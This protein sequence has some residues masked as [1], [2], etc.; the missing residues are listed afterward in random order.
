VT[1]SQEWEDVYA[2]E[3]HLSVWPWTDLVSLCLRHCQPKAEMKVLE[4]GCGSGANIPFFKS[5][6]ADYFAID[7]SPTAVA[8]LRARYPQYADQIIVGDFTVD[9]PFTNTFDLVIDRAAL[10]HNTTEAIRNC[11][12][13]V[14]HCLGD[15]GF[16]VG[17]DWFSTEFSEMSAGDVDVDEFSK[18]GFDTGKLAGVGVTHLSDKTH[19][20]DLLKNFDVIALEHKTVNRYRPDDGWQYGAW[21]FVARRLKG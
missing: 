21:N 7:G 16:F 4:L 2:R 12:N 11:L 5:M 10:T 17:I 3:M 9:V 13:M 15:D 20:L 18:S 19:L 6:T 14:E 1:F 8:Q